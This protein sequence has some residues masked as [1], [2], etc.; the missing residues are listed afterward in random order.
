MKR[1]L[2]EKGLVTVL[3]IMVLVVFSFAD[4][5]SKKLAELYNR[6][7]GVS[8]KKDKDFSSAIEHVA[9]ADTRL[10]RN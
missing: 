6:N 1:T 5:D 4:R 3:F 10:S 9:T 2:S 7:A 8:I